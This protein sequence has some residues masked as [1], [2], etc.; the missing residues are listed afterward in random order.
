MRAAD[1]G[2]GDLHDALGDAGRE[3]GEDA[4][5]DFERGQVARVHPDDRGA[6][7]DR[8]R[9]R[10]P[11]R[12]PGDDRPAEDVRDLLGT[13]RAS[14]LLD[15]DEAWLRQ[16]NAGRAAIDRRFSPEVV[17]HGLVAALALASTPAAVV[18][19]TSWV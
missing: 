8:A 3:P 7:V 17:E 11:G 14:G 18:G 16:S 19:G 10:V 4:P 12:D 1:A 13:D 5:V 15:D 2:L 6:G 9:D